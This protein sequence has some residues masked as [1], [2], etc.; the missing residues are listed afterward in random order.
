MLVLKD[1]YNKKLFKYCLK[2]KQRIKIINIIQQFEC[3]AK[4][5]YKL[6]ICKFKH[7]N[8]RVVIRI[9]GKTIYKTQYIEKGI[10]IKLSPS[11]IKEPARAFKQAGQE[12]IIKLIKMRTF[13]NLFKNLQLKIM[14][15]IIYL[16]NKS[17]SKTY[18]Y[19]LLNKTLSS[20]F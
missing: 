14:L 19:L 2:S 6:L 3:Q 5:Q 8:K 17:L 1:K 18:N 15:A 10:D 16:Y 7:N 11:Y 9:K 12:V 20:Q 4:R 13:A